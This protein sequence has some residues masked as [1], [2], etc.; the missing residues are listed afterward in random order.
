[1]PFT[2]TLVRQFSDNVATN[3]NQPC[4]NQQVRMTETVTAYTGLQ[5]GGVF[6]YRVDPV[7]LV[8]RYDHIAVPCDLQRYNLNVVT[9]GAEFIRKISIDMYYAT[10]QAAQEG[11]VVIENSVQ[12]LVDELAALQNMSAAVTTTISS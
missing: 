2:V 10:A 4:D 12:D 3:A 9:P 1:M 7:T 5:D 8:P 6:V 11:A